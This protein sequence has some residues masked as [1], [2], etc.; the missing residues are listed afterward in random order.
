MGKIKISI[1]L[2]TKNNAGTIEEVLK[3]IRTQQIEYDFEVILVDSGSS[4]NSIDLISKYNVR[5]YKIPPHEFGHGRTRNL[6][7][8]YAAGDYFVFLSADAIPYDNYWLKNLINELADEKI[9]AVF[10]RQIP[11]EASPP[12]ER[13]FIM[14]NY[15][16]CGDAYSGDGF[17][18]NAFFSNVNSV[19]RR[20]V[21]INIKFNE[22]M[23][24]SEDYDW[25]K[26][27]QES[28]Y[29]IKYA[30]DAAVIHSHN[31]TLTQAFKRFFDSGVSF[32]QMGLKPRL[33][34]NGIH[35]FFEEMIYIGEE[36]IFDIPYAICYDG[37]KLIGYLA[38]LNH[39]W[40]PASIKVHLSMHAYFWKSRS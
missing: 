17:A 4:D 38:G 36:N 11:H 22:S 8:E 25:A 35:Y 10:G 7:S 30:P 37:M 27:A 21:W 9:G 6:A 34:V 1:I 32:S 14:K 3:K 13:F 26:R 12:M 24:I 20:S 18:M 16:L 2:L 19:I 5:L 15:P 31:Y 40:I 29:R 33:L 39:K 28:G 23:I